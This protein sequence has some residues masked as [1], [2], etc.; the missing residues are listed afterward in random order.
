MASRSWIQASRTALRNPAGPTPT[1]A[2]VMT[3]E[4]RMAVPVASG[5]KPQIAA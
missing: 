5:W 4:T 2:A 1:M 3:A